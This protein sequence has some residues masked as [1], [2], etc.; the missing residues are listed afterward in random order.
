MG[1]TGAC[2]ITVLAKSDRMLE[3]VVEPI[4]SPVRQRDNLF[5]SI[6]HVAVHA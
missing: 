6:Q 2:D 1:F 5:N 3:I 4:L